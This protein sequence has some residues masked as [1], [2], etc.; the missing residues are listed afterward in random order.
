MSKL[1]VHVM[2]VGEKTPMLQDE[3]GW[4]LF[5]LFC[6]RHPSCGVLESRSTSFAT[7]RLKGGAAGGMAAVSAVCEASSSGSCLR[8]SSRLV[9]SRQ[10]SASLSE[11]IKCH[12]RCSV[13]R[14]VCRVCFRQ[15][16]RVSQQSGQAERSGSDGGAEHHGY[17]QVNVELMWNAEVTCIAHCDHGDDRR[18]NA[19]R[20]R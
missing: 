18:C 7:D 5:H 20:K 11:V 9:F 19:A 15:R 6:P 2:Q 1:P 16:G 13:D 4:P 12:W 8:N 10:D 3:L 14:Q 17:C